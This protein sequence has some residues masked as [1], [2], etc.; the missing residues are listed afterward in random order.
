M[1]SRC[2]SALARGDWH[3]RVETDGHMTATATD[4]LVTHALDA[5][6][7][8]DRVCARTCS[9]TFPRDGA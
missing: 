5:Y 9:L 4:F 3:T 7:G 8:D 2:S 6:E 1:R